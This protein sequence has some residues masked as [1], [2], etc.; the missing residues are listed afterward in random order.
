MM[1][2]SDDLY[3][4][5]VTSFEDYTA[6]APHPLIPPP[7]HPCRWAIEHVVG[8]SDDLYLVTVTPFED[9]TADAT[10]ILQESYDYAHNAGVSHLCNLWS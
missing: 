7:L 3:L 4:V 2:S 5:T 8:S 10:R 9:Y 6:D 1:G